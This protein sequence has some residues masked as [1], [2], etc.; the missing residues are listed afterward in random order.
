V[1]L[2]VGAVVTAV[3]LGSAFGSDTT[4]SDAPF[5][6]IEVAGTDGVGIEDSFTPAPA[7]VDAAGVVGATVTA[8]S[9]GFDFSLSSV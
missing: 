9:A 7:G 4:G 3:A 1:S 2:L 5:D 6:A 8:G